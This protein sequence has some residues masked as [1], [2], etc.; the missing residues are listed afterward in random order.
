[1]TW[2]I[3]AALAALCAACLVLASRLVQSR[4][5][6][7]RAEAERRRAIEAADQARRAAEAD[8]RAIARE[9]E[10]VVE[11]CGAGVAILAPD[12]RVRRANSEARRLLDMRAEALGRT[13][14]EATLSEELHALVRAAMS[15][16]EA[17][18]AQIRLRH[19]DS[20]IVA[21]AVAPIPSDESAAQWALVVHDV[22]DLRRLE[23]IR[24]D[25]VANVSH[26][27]RTPLASILAMA[28]TLQDGA[29]DDAT[30]AARFLQAIIEEAQR[31]TRI[32]NDLLV[33]ADAETHPPT[34]TTFDLS[35]LI[36]EVADRLQPAARRAG[37]TLRVGSPDGIEVC[38]HEDQIEQVLLNLI[39]NAIKYTPA[40]GSVEI[41]VE[42]SPG[43]VAVSV[44]DTGIGIMREHLPRIFERFYRVDKARS[45]RSGG[46]GLGL[47]IV[48][49]IVEAHGGRVTVESEYGRGSTFTFT[50]PEP[51]VADP[52]G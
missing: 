30:V 9:Y 35:A 11:W 34:P 7:S 28:E 43:S 40:G 31:L 26:E 4:S 23:T 42:R 44:S 12:G 8:A 13:I 52:G 25:F 5:G 24:R 27:L 1:M 19:Q 14:L 17:Q 39:D 18:Q 16:G 15:T 47:S 48:K 51:P 20:R 50:L 10:A 38:A 29:I 36:S 45:R 37:V 33:L 6:A 21:A 22:T 49:H 32:S 2:P 3:V 46:T 41:G